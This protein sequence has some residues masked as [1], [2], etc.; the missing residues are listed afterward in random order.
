MPEV[1]IV[2]ERVRKLM[3][4]HGVGIY[5]IAE[6]TGISKASL[7]LYA[8]L[9]KT[10]VDINSKNLIL[11]A[12][13]FGTS[14]DYL[15]GVSDSP[16]GDAGEQRFAEHTCLSVESVENIRVMSY[17]QRSNILD[18][19]FSECSEETAALLDS[20]QGYLDLKHT[21]AEDKQIMEQQVRSCMALLELMH[22]L[23]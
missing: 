16:V 18:E 4:E 8:S 12:N 19:L 20:L 17:S 11:L 7:S 23:K 3:N 10:V 1:G 2:C 21:G 6:Q 5:A 22:K 9:S 15:L 14:C 13:Y